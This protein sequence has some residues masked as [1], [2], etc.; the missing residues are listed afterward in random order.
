MITFRVIFSLESEPQV[1]IYPTDDL[2]ISSDTHII[3]HGMQ[4][5]QNTQRVP[6]NA[7]FDDY[8]LHRNYSIYWIFM[9]L[10]CVSTSQPG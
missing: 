5:Y 6:D 9:V 10:F 3:L 4:V 2:E 8:N 1:Y 7:Q